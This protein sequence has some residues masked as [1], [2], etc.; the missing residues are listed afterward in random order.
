MLLG[1]TLPSG[2]GLVEIEEG[3]RAIVVP[4]FQIPWV[5]KIDIFAVLHHTSYPF[6]IAFTV[7]RCID[8]K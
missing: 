6:D 7:Y 5:S 3:A 4:K 8:I 2:I 1:N